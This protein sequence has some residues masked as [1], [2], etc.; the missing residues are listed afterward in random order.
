[1]KEAQTA[2]RGILDS[3]KAVYEELL[4]LAEQQSDALIARR[5]SALQEIESRQS[6]LLSQASRL[7]EKVAS[8][9]RELSESFGM[10]GVPT[11]SAVAAH[12]EAPVRTAL[13]ALCADIQKTLDRINRVIRL[14]AELFESAMDCVRFTVQLMAGGHQPGAVC[15]PAMEAQRQGA[16]LVVD[17][18]V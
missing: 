17:Q 5:V 12:L 8:R 3:Q 2:L 7:E 1:M 11:V 4:S 15:Y 14:N 13:L 10:T 16:S 6:T 9:L 18:R